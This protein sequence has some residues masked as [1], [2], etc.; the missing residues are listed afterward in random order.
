MRPRRPRRRPPRARATM[1]CARP[2][3]EQVVPHQPD[4]LARPRRLLVGGDGGAAH[5]R[6]RARR[7]GHHRGCVR[8]D[9]DSAPPGHL[10]A[11]APVLMVN[12]VDRALLEQQLVN[13]RG[14]VKPPC[15]TSAQCAHFGQR[16]HRDLLISTRRSA[17]AQV[18]PEKGNRAIELG[19][20]RGASRSTYSDARARAGDLQVSPDA[21]TI[22]FVGRACTSGPSPCR[23]SPSSTP[24]S[25][26]SRRT[27]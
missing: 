1:I 27:R 7:G 20:D 11:R 12:K 23:A 16:D 2:R 6:R 4:R 9:R 14:R 5:H 13:G 15:P 26:A 24:R 17:T 10:R 22:A 3:L 25:S 18:I 21:G 8:A 19:P